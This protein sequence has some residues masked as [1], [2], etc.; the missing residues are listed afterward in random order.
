EP[1]GHNIALLWTDFIRAIDAQSKPVATIE[2]A[3]RASV[4]PLLGMISWR[5]GRSLRW[6]GAKEQIRDDPEANAMLQRSYR[7]PWSYPV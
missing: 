7:A 1:D 3:H 6:D 2:I 4:L 5:A